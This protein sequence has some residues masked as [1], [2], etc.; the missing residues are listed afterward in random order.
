MVE[1]LPDLDATDFSGCRIL[2]QVE[3]RN[4]TGAAQPR[5]QVAQRHAGHPAQ[6]QRRP[7]PLRTRDQVLG[8]ALVVAEGPVHLFLILDVSK[9]GYK[10]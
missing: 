2:H 8:Q 10:L 5:L 7:Q 6:T 1:P 4:A 3:Q 9:S